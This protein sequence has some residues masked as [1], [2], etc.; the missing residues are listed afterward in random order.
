M[1]FLTDHSN[2]TNIETKKSKMKLSSAFLFAVAAADKP[3]HPQEQLA[4][5][6]QF[7]EDLLTTWFDFLSPQSNGSQSKWIQK[8]AKNHLR[9]ER[10]LDRCGRFNPE[11]HCSAVLGECSAED[12]NLEDP[13]EGVKQLTTKYR[14]FAEQYLSHCRGQKKYKHQIHRM[15]HWNL[16]LQERLTA[17]FAKTTTTTSTTTTSTTT[18]TTTSKG[19]PTYFRFCQESTIFKVVTA[20]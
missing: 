14:E 19:N 18:T 12:Y 11:N 9:M 6:N 2:L 13:A 7:A 5:L 3:L 17:Y 15:N 10:S 4:G 8:F 1:I 16:M 20:Y